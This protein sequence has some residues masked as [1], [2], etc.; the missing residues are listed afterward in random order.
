MESS[1]ALQRLSDLYET[2]IFCWF[3]ASFHP[4]LLQSNIIQLL[5]DSPSLFAHPFN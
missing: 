2:H 1:H 3:L 5:T 4:V